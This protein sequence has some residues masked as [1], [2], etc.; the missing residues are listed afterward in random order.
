MHSRQLA[1]FARLTRHGK[2]TRVPPSPP[3]GLPAQRG[4]MRGAQP[5]P[6]SPSAGLNNPRQNSALMI[7]S[8]LSCFTNIVVSLYFSAR[9]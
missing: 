9:I 5:A 3:K 7:S 6:S 4:N 8:Y 2:L 1:L